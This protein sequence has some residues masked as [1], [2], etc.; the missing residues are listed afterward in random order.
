MPGS[1]ETMKKPPR[2]D[3]L[4]SILAI[5]TATPPNAVEQVDFPDFY[6][7]ITGSEHLVDLKKKFRRICEK[8]AI[9]KRYFSWDEELIKKNPSLRTFDEPSLD[10][11]QKLA[12]EQ[13]PKLG[14]AAAR[15]AIEEWGQPKSRITHLIFSTLSGVDLPGA[16]YILTKHL[17]LSPSVQRVMLYHV[18]CFAGGTVLRLAKDLAESSRGAR[19]LVVCSETTSAAVIRGPSEEHLDDLVAQSL[20][21][22]G[23]SALIVGADADERAGERVVFSIISASQLVI[24][25]SERAIGGRFGEGG[26][27]ALFHRD[28]PG[29]ISGSIGKCLEEAF[30]PLGVRDWNSIF[31]AAHPGGRAI[32]DRLEE[33]VGLR[34]ERLSATR[35]VLAEYGNLSSACVLFILD[36]MRRRSAKEGKGTTGEGLEL[37]VLF[38]FGPGLTIETVVLRASPIA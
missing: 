24:P 5:G 11:R 2:A 34:P 16:D 32:L 38:G 23:A 37:G 15:A 18:G 19:V 14:A 13:I 9:R 30:S 22:D 21:A 1:L 20:F 3:G 17:G 25:D 6:F 31:W 7:R 36:E 35:H 4:A 28:A 10:A 29:V 33:T 27:H 26:I 8:T 12:V